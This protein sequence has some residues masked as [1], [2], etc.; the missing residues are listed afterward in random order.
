VGCFYPAVDA[1]A[2]ERERHTWETLMTVAASRGSI[3]TAKYLY[4]ATMGC[5]AGLL[6]LAAMVVTI[7]PILAP[8]VAKSG[9][10]LEFS[11]PLRA[12]PVMAAA[13]VLL[14]GFVAAGMMVFAAFARTF[15]EGQSMITPFYMLILL[16]VMFLQVPG[17]EFSF[18][19]AAIPVIN[20]TMMVREA[21]SGSF[22]W[23]QIVL[24]MGVS[25]AVIAASLGL[26]TFILRFEDVMIGSYGGRLA[27]F[28]RERVLK[29]AR[30]PVRTAG[31]TR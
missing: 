5:V 27:T 24:T 20:V 25:V 7:K 4:V 28:L 31:R 16:P 30:K 6:N 18:L 8:L 29:V 19:L 14:A 17:L 1:T 15:K 11:M 23:P 3:V 13:A 21:I 26:A 9:E 10:V 2:G 12:V 22:H